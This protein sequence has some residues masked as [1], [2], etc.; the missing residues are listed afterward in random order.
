MPESAIISI[1][2]AQAGSPGVLCAAVSGV[3]DDI[4]SVTCTVWCDTEDTHSYPAEKHEDGSWQIEVSSADHGFRTGTYRLI[5][6]TDSTEPHRILGTATAELQYTGGVLTAEPADEQ[7]TQIALRLTGA[8]L[9]AGSP[10]W[11]RSASVQNPDDFRVYFGHLQPDGSYAGMMFPSRH[12]A[13]GNYHISAFVHSTEIACTE[14]ELPGCSSASVEADMTDVSAGLFEI[15]AHADAPSG[16]FR[17]SAA[18]WASPDQSDIEWLTMEQFGDSWITHTS[19]AAHAHRFGT[20]NVH[21]YAR[22][23]NG[24]QALAAAR[25]FQLDPVRYTYVEQPAPGEYVITMLGTGLPAGT[26]LQLPTWSEENG[27]DDLYWYTAVVGEDGSVHCPLNLSLHAASSPVFFTHVYH[28]SEV[29]GAATY[30]V[31][32]VSEQPSVQL[33]L[34]RARQMVYDEVGYDLHSVYLWTVNNIKYTPRPW[35]EHAPAGYTREQWFALE[36]FN[37][38][39]GD[40]F[41]YAAAFAELARGLGYDAQYVEGYVWSV[42]GLWADHGFV[43]IRQDGA[44]YV[45]DPEL[46]SVS[47]KPRNLFMQPVGGSSAKYKW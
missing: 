27:Q 17:L 47:T 37:E 24:L 40:C 41:V 2:F 14:I 11:F 16:I 45:C 4:A 26:T 19:A 22:L 34:S 43:I 3:P 46:Q 35:Q 38:R 20:Y 18:V 5:A 7:Y 13:A 30:D 29:L 23:G 10:V 42:R 12:G 6:W 36:G 32:D 15:R 39:K 31:P 44:T 25:T 33:Q 21:I 9:P 1:E 28:G 8:E